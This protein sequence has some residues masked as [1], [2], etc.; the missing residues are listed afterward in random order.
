M[1]GIVFALYMAAEMPAAGRGF[2][3]IH[4]FAGYATESG[5]HPTRPQFKPPT[6]TSTYQA[7]ENQFSGWQR[8]L[9][10]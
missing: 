10:G 4:D 8:D 2:T 3:V 6:E 7:A 9:S 5:A 1:A